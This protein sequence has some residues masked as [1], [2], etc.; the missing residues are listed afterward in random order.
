MFP[1]FQ[2][3]LPH[4]ERAYIRS[5]FDFDASTLQEV[6]FKGIYQESDSIKPG[7]TV[8]DVGGHIGSFTLKV[9][10][11]VGP[12]GLVVTIEPSTENFNLL[13]RNVETNRLS[14][15]R[16][17]KVAAGSR[18]GGEV[19]LQLAKRR[20]ENSLYG[21]AK[22]EPIGRERVPMRTVDSIVQELH[23]TR[24]DFMKIDVEG[25]ELEVLKGSSETLLKYGPAIAMETHDFGPSEQEISAFLKE[26]GYSVRIEPYR[27]RL[28]LLHAKRA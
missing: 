13:S 20:G 12:G 10:G 27:S 5:A 16:L 26:R 14:N 6:Y 7:D 17:Y 19:D 23:L 22:S 21:A 8:V 24:V 2:V 1:V 4:G 15:V 9:A 3:T 18:E 11:E 25:A 28:G